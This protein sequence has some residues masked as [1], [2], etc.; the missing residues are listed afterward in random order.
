MSRHLLAAGLA[1]ALIA[2]A[3]AF[4]SESLST[5]HPHA[6]AQPLFAESDDG[7]ADAGDL[8]NDA[9]KEGN[10]A[11]T[12]TAE[13]L[14]DDEALRAK[15]IAESFARAKAAAT[16]T[17]STAAPI[18]SDDVAITMVMDKAKKDLDELK[19]QVGRV[20]EDQVRELEKREAEINRL[21]FSLVEVREQAEESARKAMEAEG[22]IKAL[23]TQVDD[24]KEKSKGLI[25]RIKEKFKKERAELTTKVNDMSEELES[26]KAEKNLS[27]IAALVREKDLEKEMSSIQSKFSA[28]ESKLGKV[29]EEME[30]M[31]SRHW[32]QLNRQKKEARR[33]Q[34]ASDR[35]AAQDKRDLRNKAWALETALAAA[36][37]DLMLAQKEIK[38]L[39][40]EQVGVEAKMVEMQGEMKL[41]IAS[42]L[43]RIEQ[44][45]VQLKK[46]TIDAMARSKTEKYE[47]LRAAGI[48]YD[49]LIALN[50]ERVREAEQAA[51]A[52][53]RFVR[54]EMNVRM[55][56][57]EKILNRERIAMKEQNEVDAIKAKADAFREVKIVQETL[58]GV[59]KDL[60]RE[61]LLVATLEG[62]RKSFRKIIRMALELAR[63]RTS[64]A[65]KKVTGRGK[66]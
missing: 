15:E 9:L 2:L 46:D 8:C 18:T 24:G 66:K 22:L 3:E 61:A 44:G 57:H 65:V 19:F 5:Q 25:A 7:L 11:G 12:I 27:E 62:E 58:Q 33:L 47:V 21:K 28:S 16:S 13:L 42:A 60:Q 20:D 48:K 59:E 41:A 51:E 50:E 35:V 56:D 39:K 36:K 17:G 4:T 23:E 6:P 34:E 54:Q 31:R 32:E 52:K 37:Y 1:V 10:S 43:A 14:M 45:R 55:S 40:E 26:I 29:T 38:R 64:N 30:E 63:E 53:V 49:T